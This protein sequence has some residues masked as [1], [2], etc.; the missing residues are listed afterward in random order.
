NTG[1]G[2]SLAVFIAERGLKVKFKRMG[3]TN[4]SPS[5]PFEELYRLFRLDETSLVETVIQ[6]IKEKA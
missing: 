6:G 1:L 4:Y 2:C 3:I 5:G